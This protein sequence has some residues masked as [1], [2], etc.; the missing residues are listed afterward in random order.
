[1]VLHAC[2]RHYCRIL[3]VLGCRRVGER[4]SLVELDRERK[5][6]VVRRVVVKAG[7]GLR[8]GCHG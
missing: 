8:R 7:L 2:Y 6:A 5:E 1:V 3:W 4:E